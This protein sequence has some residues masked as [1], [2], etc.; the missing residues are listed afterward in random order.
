MG[1]LRA[2]QHRTQHFT[3]HLGSLITVMTQNKSLLKRCLIWFG[4]LTLCLAVFIA[5]ADI[6]IIKF[7]RDQI[8]RNFFAEF[9][10]IGIA[11]PAPDK[12]MSWTMPIE[13]KTASPLAEN[14]FIWWEASVSKE[15]IKLKALLSS[16]NY[17]QKFIKIMPCNQY[18]AKIEYEQLPEGIYQVLLVNPDNTTVK[19]STVKALNTNN[20]GGERRWN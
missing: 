11:D 3:I 13:Y 5:T 2:R 10:G 17:L 7:P 1:P 20:F 18:G 16:K 19:L 14:E 12:D 6:L 8:G 9:H 15:Q 4:A